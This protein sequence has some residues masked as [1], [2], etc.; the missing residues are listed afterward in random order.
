[1]LEVSDTGIKFRRRA[2]RVKS[3]AFCADLGL[4]GTKA[5]SEAVAAVFQR[6]DLRTDLE[7]MYD[8]VQAHNLSEAKFRA[9]MI[10][11][12]VYVEAN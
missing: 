12:A 3:S 7:H 9:N 1:M 6:S 2:G 10:S 5:T 4:H 8:A 11:A